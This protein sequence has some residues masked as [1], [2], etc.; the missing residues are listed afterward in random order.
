MAEPAA[1]QPLWAIA[2]PDELAWRSWEDGLVVYDARSDQTN[3]Y[4]PITAEVFEE[5]QAGPRRLDALAAAVAERL[6]VLADGELRAMVSEIL[7]VLCADNIA[8]P[9]G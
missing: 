1:K 5:L 6:G 3:R 7:R 9:V 2:D 4:D 8:V